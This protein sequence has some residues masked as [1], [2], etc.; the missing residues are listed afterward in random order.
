MALI[1]ML[2][3]IIKMI[4]NIRMAITIHNILTFMRDKKKFAFSQEQEQEIKDHFYEDVK[5]LVYNHLF[6]GV[7][8]KEFYEHIKILD[9]NEE[10][11][12]CEVVDNCGGAEFTIGDL[13]F[14]VDPDFIKSYLTVNKE[15]DDSLEDIILGEDI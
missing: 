11:C 1:V 9:K 12:F 2:M 10:Y 3:V 5:D 4:V 15:G 7:I 6:Q 14:N 8:T 13:E